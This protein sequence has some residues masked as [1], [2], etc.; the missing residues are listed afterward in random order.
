MNRPRLF[1]LLVVSL[2]V[3]ALGKPFFWPAPIKDKGA[4]TSLL[5]HEAN[6]LFAQ[7]DGPRQ[8]LFPLDHGPHL[9]FKQEWWY[10]TGNL[11]SLPKGRVFGYQLTL[12]RI[13]AQ[14]DT[15]PIKRTSA[16]ATTQFYLGH[17]ALTDVQTGRFYH[18]QRLSRQALGLAG[19]QINP[20]RVWL[21]GWSLSQTGGT[22]DHPHLQLNATA[23][24]LSLRL[25]LDSLKPVVLQGEQGLSRKSEQ[26]QAASYYY[27]LTRLATSG[28]ILLDNHRFQVQGLSWMDREWSTSALAP[29]QIG[30]DW[31]SL[32]LDNQREIMFY[33]MRTK[34]GHDDAQSQGTLID[35]AGHTIRLG[36]EDFQMRSTGTWTSPKTGI[37]YPSGWEIKIPAHNIQLTLTPR[38]PDQELAE[39][40]IHYW[41]GAVAILGEH[42][43]KSVTGGGYVELTGYSTAPP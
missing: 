23:Q 26:T 32:Q 20:F 42:F 2:V 40:A 27:S 7:A 29:N 9:D 18:F 14:P 10:V 39:A 34:E 3:I 33:R 22:P 17:L 31:F 8:F 41:E 28:E 11:E 43:N 16:W 15:Q 1:G 25:E 6:P 38:L 5:S 12:F 35:P 19:A 24:N 13:G 30:W 37:R 4:I 21:E 36:R